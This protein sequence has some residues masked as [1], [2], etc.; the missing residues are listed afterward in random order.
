MIDALD[1]QITMATN[2]DIF[3]GLLMLF[4][5]SFGL[6]F[7]NYDL[8]LGFRSTPL[9]HS[10]VWRANNL[11]HNIFATNSSS[12]NNLGS[13][14]S[15]DS[16][17][18]TAPSSVHSIGN[19]STTLLPSWRTAGK[20]PHLYLPS[21]GE[22]LN[23][24]KDGYLQDDTKKDSSQPKT[25]TENQNTH[26]TSQVNTHAGSTGNYVINGQETGSLMTLFT[27]FKNTSDRI[28]IQLNTVRNWAQF[29]PNIQPVLFSTFQ[30]GNVLSPVRGNPGP[31]SKA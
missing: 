18:L 26:S 5:V 20:L 2:R 16:H 25:S 24:T 31:G 1:F 6:I 3:G 13:L 21:R 7:L 28:N 9:I 4:I 10:T 8:R 22:K 17:S 30:S 15:L 23:L 11:I 29:L 27:T 12:G 19:L 14:S